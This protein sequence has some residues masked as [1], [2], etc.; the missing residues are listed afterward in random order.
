MGIKLGMSSNLSES[1]TSED[2]EEIERG[3]K[4]NGDQ[5][6]INRRP[7]VTSYLDKYLCISCIANILYDYAVLIVYLQ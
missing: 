2:I 5:E 4:G 3:T 1:F 7:A 6:D